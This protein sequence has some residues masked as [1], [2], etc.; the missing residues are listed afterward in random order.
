MTNQMSK[1]LSS[2]ADTTQPLQEPLK[3]NIQWTWKESQKQAL[4][5]FKKAL[6]HS[7]VLAMYDP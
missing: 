1:F 7:L 2:L 5:S 3:A 6:C 4:I